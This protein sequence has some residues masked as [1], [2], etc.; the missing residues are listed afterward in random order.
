MESARVNASNAALDASRRHNPSALFTHML[1]TASAACHGTL[2]MPGKT[3]RQM[4]LARFFAG[5]PQ[6]RNE[7]RG[8]PL[9]RRTAGVSRG[10]ARNVSRKSA[11]SPSDLLARIQ[12]KAM[13]PPVP[14]TQLPS[15][16]NHK[17]S[18]GK[19]GWMN[20]WTDGRMDRLMDGQWTVQTR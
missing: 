9:G 2:A 13:S 11:P 19:H 14:L 15:N 8:H 12:H 18:E 6:P 5:G 1:T 16:P 7:P 20:A 17:A 4:G 3:W 10:Q